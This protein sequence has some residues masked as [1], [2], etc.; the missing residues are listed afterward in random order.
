M[1]AHQTSMLAA[2]LALNEAVRARR[3]PAEASQAA[4]PAAG[5]A[6]E[7]LPDDFMDLWDDEPRRAA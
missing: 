2:V 3:Q 7:G 6:E 5:A 4:A 1:T